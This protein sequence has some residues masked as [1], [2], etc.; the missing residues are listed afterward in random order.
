LVAG[1]VLMVVALAGVM[2]GLETEDKETLLTLQGNT[3]HIIA[4]SNAVV[5]CVLQWRV[6]RWCSS[7]WPAS[8]ASTLS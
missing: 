6:R 2:V 7:T 5:S 4:C 8:S 3:L 1:R